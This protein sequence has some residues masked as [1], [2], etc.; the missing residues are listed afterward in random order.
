MKNALHYYYGLT[1][2]TI[3][4]MN[5][6]YSFQ[7]D[8]SRYVLMP[9]ERDLEELKQIYQLTQILREGG[10]YCHEIILNNSG[11]ILTYINQ[12][13]YVLLKLFVKEDDVVILS[14]LILFQ[15]KTKNIGDYSI[16][17][18]DD[19]YQLW[20]NKIDYFEYQVS[21]LSKKHPRIRESFSYFVGLAETSIS[22]FHML[23]KKDTHI[24]SVAH[25][26]IQLGDTLFDLYNPLNFILDIP[27]RDASEYFKSSFFNQPDII[28]EIIYYLTYSNLTEYECQMFFIRLLF[29]TFYFDIYEDV[30]LDEKN[31]KELL[32]V[33][34]HTND[35]ERMIALTY[36]YLK[37]II[38]LPEIEWLNKLVVNY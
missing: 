1:I 18:R 35:Y 25:K 29:P 36:Q 22:L 4:Q 9:V 16:L 2:Q 5:K 17:K 14:D 13:S 28:N 19:W 11:Q 27:S 6:R 20:T 12:V 8:K 7:I 24:L 23:E 21:Q 33:V 30:I 37:T 38:Y 32:K 34:T 31:E 26:R 10:L 15:N 3:H